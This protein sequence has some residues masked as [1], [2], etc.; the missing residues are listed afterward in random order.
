[1]Q[2]HKRAIYAVVS[3]GMI[4]VRA[5]PVC[6][7]LISQR[8]MIDRQLFHKSFLVYIV[9]DRKGVIDHALELATPGLA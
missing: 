6:G 2:R 8:P 1:M 7:L 4:E 9:I 5:N 3:R